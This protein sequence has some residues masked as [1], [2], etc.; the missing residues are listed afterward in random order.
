MNTWCSS[1]YH[2]TLTLYA[3]TGS[4]WNN[5]LAEILIMKA[6]ILSG[7]R[8]SLIQKNLFASYTNTGS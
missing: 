6:G 5:V 3:Y 1:N 7:T 2:D 8:T 4:A